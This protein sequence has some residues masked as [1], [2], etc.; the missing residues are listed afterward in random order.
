[1]PITIREL[2]ASDTISQAA[3]K[4]NFNFDQLLLNGGGPQGPQGP[5]GPPGPI[6]GRGIR[7]SVWYEGTADPTVI[8]PTA[9]PE[10]EDNYLQSNGDVW[11]YDAS[12][13][14]WVNTGVNLTGP[15]GPTGASGKFAEY[16]TVPYNAAGDTTIFPDEMSFSANLLNQ[17][18]RSVLIGGFPE[19]PAFTPTLTGTNIVPSSIASQ[20]QMPDISM[21]VHQFN[22]AGRGIVFHGGDAT[23]NF[24]QV[25]A[26]DLSSI[27][28]SNDDLMVISVPKEP[29]LSS[30]QADLDGLRVLTPERNQHFQAGKRIWLQ[31]GA[32]SAQYGAGD[33]ASVLIET[34]RNIASIPNPTIELRVDD[35]AGP[36]YNAELQLGGFGT[37]PGT[38][39]KQGDFWVEAGSIGILSS[40][41]TTVNSGQ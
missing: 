27:G 36:G 22:A 11:T 17:G 5:Q 21:M 4:I 38:S 35:T 14:A 26:T 37:T 8:P 18:V 39:S 31:A 13:P 32:S 30:V 24:E 12:I 23:E 28:I 29:T 9:T 10:D 40:G 19:S 20:L 16:Q 1:M 33:R 41:N 25:A 34:D 15:T 3:D 6:G 2:L 7:G